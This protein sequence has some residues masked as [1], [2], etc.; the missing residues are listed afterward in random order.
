MYLW[1][2]L[3]G[4]TMYQ[5]V[6]TEGSSDYYWLLNSIDTSDSSQTFAVDINYEGKLNSFT[7]SNKISARAVVVSK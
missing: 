3:S 1:N 5:T 7:P 4:C 6:C 2:F